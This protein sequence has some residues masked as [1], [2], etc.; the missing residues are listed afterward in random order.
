ML[1][2]TTNRH[3]I[4]LGMSSEAI[5]TVPFS[6]RMSVEQYRALDRK[7]RGYGVSRAE[8]IRRLVDAVDESPPAREQGREGVTA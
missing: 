1:Y 6:L 5:P 4:V 7:A 2:R 8:M 3:H